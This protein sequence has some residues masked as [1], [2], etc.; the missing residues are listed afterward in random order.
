MREALH[1]WENAAW[2]NLS[3]KG[4]TRIMKPN[5]A[6]TNRGELRADIPGKA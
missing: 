3:G 1:S 2:N 4:A 5:P 6:P